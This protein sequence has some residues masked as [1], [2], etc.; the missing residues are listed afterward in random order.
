MSAVRTWWILPVIW[1]VVAMLAVPVSAS[2]GLRVG[3][4]VQVSSDPHFQREVALA[5]NPADDRNLIAAANDASFQGP[6]CRFDPSFESCIWVGLYTSRDRGR[7]WRANFIPGYPGGPRGVLSEFN[8]GYDPFVA[9]DREGAAY[10]GGIFANVDHSCAPCV[11]NLDA[12][13]AIARRDDGGRSWNDPVIV[14]RGEGS[15]V[16]NDF[17]HIAVDTSRGVGHGRSED[18]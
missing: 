10:A 17:P 12:S 9:F 1:A 18:R 11:P 3:R 2:H 5:V 16:V 13:R 6:D 8:I 15:N 7:S 14:A 4:N